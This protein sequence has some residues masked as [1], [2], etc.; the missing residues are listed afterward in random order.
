MTKYRNLEGMDSFSVV[1]QS[2]QSDQSDGYPAVLT[3]LTSNIKWI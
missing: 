1:D 3:H 2:D